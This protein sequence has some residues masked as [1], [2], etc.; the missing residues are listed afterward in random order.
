MEGA[1]RVSYEECGEHFFIPYMIE[2]VQNGTKIR[3]GDQVC[4]QVA[5]DKR[6]LLFLCHQR[7]CC[8]A[9]RDCF[10]TSIC[11]IIICRRHTFYSVQYLK[12]GL[13]D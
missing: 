13:P 5:T 8:V 9:Y 11:V 10:I 1:G 2:D 7:L 12:N 4:F 3:Q 6:L